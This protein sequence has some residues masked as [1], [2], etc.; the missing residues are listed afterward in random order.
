MPFNLANACERGLRAYN[1][2]GSL[3]LSSVSCC[4]RV[5]PSIKQLVGEG[6]HLAQEK[7]QERTTESMA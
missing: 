5:Y 2:A 4:P 1:I 7:N 3:T 6:A